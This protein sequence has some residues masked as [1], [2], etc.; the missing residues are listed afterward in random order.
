LPAATALSIARASTG[1]AGG[2]RA[3]VN[4]QRIGIAAN[5]SASSASITIAGMRQAPAKRWP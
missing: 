2:Q 1:R 4:Q 3:D 5:C